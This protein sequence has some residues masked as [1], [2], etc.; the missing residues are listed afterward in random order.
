[1]KANLSA[2]KIKEPKCPSFY[3]PVGTCRNTSAPG[4][5]PLARWIPRHP[6]S[7]L[8][9]GAQ[10]E[11][12]ELDDGSTQ[13][14]WDH[15]QGV[16]SILDPVACLSPTAH[17]PSLGEPPSRHR[18]ARRAFKSRTM[19]RALTSSTFCHGIGLKGRGASQY[20][21]LSI[22]S[23][24]HPWK[25]CEFFLLFSLSHGDARSAIGSIPML[26]QHIRPYPVENT[27]SRPLSQSQAAEGLISSWVGDDQRIPAVVC[28]CCFDLFFFHYRRLECANIRL[29]RLT[30]TTY[31]HT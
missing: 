3:S 31:D 21:G 9:R 14:R 10:K 19:T 11:S 30:P 1:M 8:R 22:N 26:F 27:G 13:I 20:S 16:R 15:W 6:G 24:I 18:G 2:E 23:S 17:N 5:Q 7:S 29:P 4:R 12:T 25:Y 28:F